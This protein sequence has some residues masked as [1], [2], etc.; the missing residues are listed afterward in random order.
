MWRN[1]VLT[2]TRLII[3]FSILVATSGCSHFSSTASNE[4]IYAPTKVGTPVGGKVAKDI[5]P[6]G[7]TLSSPDGRLK[8][9]VPQNAL[10]EKITFTIQPIANNVQTGI[11]VAYRLG[12]DG[13]TFTIPLELSVRYDERDLEGTA[14]EALAIAFQDG[15]GK[16][17]VLDPAKLDDT[18]KS[19]KFSITHF[20]DYSFLAKFRLEP[21]KATLRV[22][23]TMQIKLIGCEETRQIFGV[24]MGPGSNHVCIMNGYQYLMNWYADVG[25][26]TGTI[27]PAIYMAP[28]RKP[29]PNVATVS[30]PYVISEEGSHSHASNPASPPNEERRG[31]FT[32]KITIV[33][34]GYRASGE[35]DWLVTFSGVICS[36]EK[37]FIVYGS[38][39]NYNLRFTPASDSNGTW[40]LD[41]FIEEG[42]VT[43]G[44]TYTIEN[45]DSDKPRIKVVGDSTVTVPGH[46]PIRGGSGTFYLD[47]VPTDTNECGGK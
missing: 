47:L 39:Y 35:G 46:P 38:A 2:N 14:A 24:T 26:I 27:N 40:T 42:K 45:L 30:F 20:T 22:G 32:A 11:G 36:L 9:T 4:I 19:V 33:D 3:V 13:K 12:P 44:G 8:L 25:T 21:S 28:P 6:A 37:P 16:W 31:M 41:T 18:N 7:G 10:A 34:R 1:N 29:H 5:G 15:E 23:E 43:G 17:H